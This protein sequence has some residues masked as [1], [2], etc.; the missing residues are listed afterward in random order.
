VLFGFYSFCIL[1]H[2]FIAYTWYSLQYTFGV[3]YVLINCT[4]KY[5]F[6]SER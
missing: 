4:L 3:V 1:K 2:G 6:Y 5:V